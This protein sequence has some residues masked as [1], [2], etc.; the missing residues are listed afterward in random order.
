MSFYKELVIDDIQDDE[1][2]NEN[3]RKICQYICNLPTKAQELIYVIIL[4]YYER[5]NK[6]KIPQSFL[7]GAA[8]RSK[9]V[10]VYSERFPL[11]LRKKILSFIKFLTR[12]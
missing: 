6:D 7:F 12:D 5:E 11:E 1:I 2:N 9:C 8:K 10:F 3:W 4:Y